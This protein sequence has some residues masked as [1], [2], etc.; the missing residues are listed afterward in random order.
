MLKKVCKRIKEWKSVFRIKWVLAVAKVDYDRGNYEKACPVF[1]KFAEQGVVRAQDLCGA[2]YYHGTAKDMEKALRWSEKAA[3]QGN[4]DSQLRC[5][6]IYSYGSYKELKKAEQW[7]H[8]VLTT[9]EEVPAIEVMNAHLGLFLG[10]AE[11]VFQ[12][13]EM[14]DSEKT[15]LQKAVEELVTAWHQP[16]EKNGATI[17]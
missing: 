11:E 12:D 2:C 4:L 10:W 16:L 17:A 14:E 6:K 5:V 1:E 9:Q 7:L 15:E 13:I 8:T 3:E